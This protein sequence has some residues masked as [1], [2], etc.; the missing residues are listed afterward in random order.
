MK[1]NTRVWFTLTLNHCCHLDSALLRETSQSIIESAYD[2]LVEVAATV[3]DIVT[4][5]S[6]STSLIIRKLS[7]DKVKDYTGILKSMVHRR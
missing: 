5:A 1:S 2:H 6:V 7:C 4:D 3:R